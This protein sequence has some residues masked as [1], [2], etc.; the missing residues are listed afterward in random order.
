MYWGAEIWFMNEYIIFCICL[1]S[2][3]MFSPIKQIVDEFFWIANMCLYI[4]YSWVVQKVVCAWLLPLHPCTMSG[5]I[6][7]SECLKKEEKKVVQFNPICQMPP[8]LTRKHA[9]A[10]AC[11]SNNTEVLSCWV[12]WSVFIT[13]KHACMFKVDPIAGKKVSSSRTTAMMTS[14]TTD[15]T[16]SSMAVRHSQRTSSRQKK[17]KKRKSD[18]FFSLQFPS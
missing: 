5:D 6:D 4:I 16:I 15:K 7:S 11:T 2:V 13:K 1:L 3:S 17:K 8:I 12:G 14:V 10:Q 18:D 9:V